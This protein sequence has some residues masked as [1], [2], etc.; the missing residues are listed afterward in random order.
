MLNVTWRRFDQSAKQ[1][2][3]GHAT[4]INRWRMVENVTLGRRTNDRVSSILS[5]DQPLA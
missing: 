4:I 5:Y 1:L 3:V 2:V